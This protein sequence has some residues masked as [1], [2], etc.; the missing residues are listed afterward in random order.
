MKQARFSEEQIIGIRWEHKAG[1]KAGELA[2]KH[3]VSEAQRLRTLED[4]I[5]KL[6][7]LLADVMLDKAALQAL[8]SKNGRVCRPAPGRELSPKR[9]GDEPAAGLS[10]V[11]ADCKM[12]RYRSRRAPETELRERW[13]GLAAERRRFGFQQLFVLLRREGE[14]SGRN[15]IYRLYSEEGLAV[16]KRRSRRRAIGARAGPGGGQG[17]CALVAGLRAR[18]A[19]QRAAVLYPQRGRRRHARIP[20]SDRRHLAGAWPV[21]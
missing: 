14:P 11:Q 20:G 1:A 12:V 16:R 6:E 17:Q 7:R 4:E 13:R 10:R 8:L 18:P 21:S 15:R 19:R 5:A 3:G 2:R 9:C